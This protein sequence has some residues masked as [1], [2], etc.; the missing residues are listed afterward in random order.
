MRKT[1]ALAGLLFSVMPLPCP[2]SLAVAQDVS[3]PLPTKE[4]LAK[5]NKLFITLARKALKWDEPAEPIKMV[6]PLY[7]VGTKGLSS[8]L[9]VTQEGHILLNTA[10][11]E[12]GQLIVESIR[13]LGFKPE[14][15]K[16]IINGHAHSDHA[17]AFAYIK[18]ISG[19][20]LAV[21]E[22]DVAQMEDGGKS[23]F[24]YGTDWKIMGFPPVKV[25]RILRDGDTVRL[26]DVLLTAYN[27]PGHTRGSTTWVTQLIDSGKVYTVVFPDGAGFNPGYRVARDPS[28]PGIGTDYRNTHHALELLKPNIWAGHHTEYFDMEEKRKRAA[29][30]GV[31]AWVDP[32]GYRRFVAEKKSA[33][34]ALVNEE[35]G[36]GAAPAK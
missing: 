30:E 27:T 18:A 16:I 21:M 5:N 11:P 36:A 22:P 8:F 13:K 15:I 32:E 34:E 28:Y 19:A 2:A 9:F 29:T 12:T 1:V 17:G 6:G 25:D 23:D 31:K 33:F 20:E 3:R 14:D 4:D 26:G 7:F 24:H 35:M 10:M